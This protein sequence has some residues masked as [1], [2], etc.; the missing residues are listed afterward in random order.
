MCNSHNHSPGCTCGFGGDGHLGRRPFYGSTY[1]YSYGSTYTYSQ[2]DYSRGLS[3][4]SYNL[5]FH[6]RVESNYNSFVN[7]FVNPNATCPVCGEA[8]FFCQTGNGGRIFFDELGPPWTKHPCT[9]NLKNRISKIPIGVLF[10]QAT[11]NKPR[12]PNTG[13]FIFLWQKEGW[14]PFSFF[15]AQ[16]VHGIFTSIEGMYEGKE[17]N[18]YVKHLEIPIN[19]IRSVPIQL[20]RIDKYTFIL[21]TFIYTD[22]GNG[23]NIFEK[24]YTAFNNLQ[25]AH[26]KS[27]K[28]K[29]IIRSTERKKTSRNNQPVKTQKP[30]IKTAFELAF[31]KVGFING[32][33][34]MAKIINFSTRQVQQ[35]DELPQPVKARAPTHFNLN[36]MPSPATSAI[37]LA[38]KDYNFREGWEVTLAS[39]KALGLKLKELEKHEVKLPEI[40]KAINM[41][42]ELKDDQEAADYFEKLL[43]RMT[44]EDLPVIALKDILETFRGYVWSLDFQI[45]ISASSYA[46]Y[47]ISSKIGR[48]IIRHIYF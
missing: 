24:K 12:V 32:E 27:I 46:E 48:P 42:L 14:K 6:D 26:L 11:I 41:A 1:T 39:Y 15:N 47:Q 21:S 10:N 8:V 29:N 40:K 30:P 25:I 13:E 2:P 45:I 22:T 3:R 38:A 44:N 5:S 36:P 17:I 9:D 18:L 7:A 23:F 16:I 31:E 33:I 43:E 4:N 37:V 20:K 34:K 19:S 28:E 35:I